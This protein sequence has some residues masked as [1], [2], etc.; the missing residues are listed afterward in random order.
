[1]EKRIWGLTLPGHTGNALL[2][3]LREMRVDTNRSVVRDE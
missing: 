1:M 3:H 2:M